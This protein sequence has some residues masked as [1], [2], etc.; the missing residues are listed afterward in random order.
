[1]KKYDTVFMSDQFRRMA[2]NSET[3][4][5]PGTGEDTRRIVSAAIIEIVTFTQRQYKY[6]RF[7]NSKRHK[8]FAK[9]R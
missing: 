2:P 7:L 1:M 8:L 4:N 5:D 9:D 6:K 3:I